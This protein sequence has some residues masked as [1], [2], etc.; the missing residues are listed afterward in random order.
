M[1]AEIKTRQILI[2]DMIVAVVTAIYWSIANKPEKNFRTSMGFDR[3]QTRQSI[4][5]ELCQIPLLLVNV[6]TFT[7]KS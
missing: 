5:L 7:R 3:T 2:E 6:F 4:N 1:D